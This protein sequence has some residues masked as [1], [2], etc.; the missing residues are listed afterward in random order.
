[1]QEFTVPS[2]TTS[3]DVMRVL[4][5]D[6][7]PE[8]LFAEIGLPI[9]R[10][11]L[12][13]P[14]MTGNVLILYKISDPGNLGTLLRTALA[15]DWCRVVLVDS[16]VDPFGPEC[17]RSSMGASLKVQ[18]YTIEKSEL[19]N[20]LKYNEISP[21]FADSNVHNIMGI[22]LPKLDKKHQ[23]GLILGSEARGFD[24]FPAE[25]YNSSQKI[26]IPMKNKTD[27]LNVA[28]SGGILM[29]ILSRNKILI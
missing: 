21:I 10:S 26:S 5:R 14:N 3:P 6:K 2:I 8:G 17:I 28:V 24:D 27:S 29:N 19:C 16:C 9:F 22:T 7:C 18:I 20:F 12:D 15:F 23:F 13:F 4:L 11:K 1:M 25:F